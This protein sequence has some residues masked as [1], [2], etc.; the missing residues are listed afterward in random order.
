MRHLRDMAIFL[1]SSSLVVV[2]IRLGRIIYSMV[3][4]VV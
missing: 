2:L 3:V 1:F 4:A